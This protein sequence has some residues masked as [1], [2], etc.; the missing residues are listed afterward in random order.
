VGPPLRKFNG[1]PE[2]VQ[3]RRGITGCHDTVKHGSKR[4]KDGQEGVISAGTTRHT[5]RID[6][7]LWDQAM[8]KQPGKVLFPGDC[9]VRTCAG[10]E[11]LQTSSRLVQTR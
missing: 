1:H 8:P 2:Y 7:D 10:S 5:V 3:R 9:P 4:L 6:D 11:V